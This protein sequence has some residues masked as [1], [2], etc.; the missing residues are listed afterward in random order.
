VNG[1]SDLAGPLCNWF[2]DRNGVCVIVAAGVANHAGAGGFRGVSGNSRAQG[3]EAEDDGDG[4]WAPVQLAAYPRVVAAGLSLMGRDA[5][6][7]CSHRTWA[8]NRKVDPAGISDDWMRRQVQ[9]IFAHP[10]RPIQE[11]DVSYEDA[12][13]AV[14]DVLKL[15]ATGLAVPP[16]QRN[17]GDM[18]VNLLG[19]AQ[20]NVNS[21]NA[22]R[23]GIAQVLAAV[24]A[25]P[26]DQQAVLAA[27]AALPKPRVALSDAELGELAA[28]YPGVDQDRIRDAV[29]FQ[30]GE[31]A[32]G[33]EPAGST[34]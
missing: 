31:S 14:R 13:R 8:P 25:E 32:N 33:A 20:G 34:G 30:V 28:A 15:P 21:V 17:N 6:W 26:N 7:Y 12:V 22:I 3:C 27:A 16:G 23:S 18:Y 5:S 1:R 29:E 11:D 4:N 2:L 24:N 19:A 10:G 9:A